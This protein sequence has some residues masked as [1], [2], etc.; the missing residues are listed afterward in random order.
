MRNLVRKMGFFVVILAIVP[1]ATF[2][3]FI[4]KMADLEPYIIVLVQLP[5][6]AIQLFSAILLIRYNE[7]I[8]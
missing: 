1:A 3:N 6:L 4:G 8:F 5:L 2:M 7:E